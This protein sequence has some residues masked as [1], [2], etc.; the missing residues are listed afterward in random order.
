MEIP[1]PA[2][3]RTAYPVIHVDCLIQLLFCNLPCLRTTGCFNPYQFSRFQYLRP[4]LA[5]ERNI[6][7]PCRILKYP[8]GVQA[9]CVF[10]Y[11]ILAVEPAAFCPAP[12]PELLLDLLFA[13][14]L[15]QHIQKRL[16]FINLQVAQIRHHAMPIPE[17]LVAAG[18]GNVDS[19]ASPIV[20]T[21]IGKLQF[22]NRF[23]C[24]THIAAP[25]RTAKAC[26]LQEA[27]A[28]RVPD[29]AYRPP[30]LTAPLRT[31]HSS[32]LFPPQECRICQ[33]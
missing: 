7:S 20:D 5:V 32:R 1:E 18:T 27:P 24:H 15:N 23:L 17:F 2:A 30:S 19:R 10:L 25:F 14:M 21:Q 13:M 29:T 11:F 22:S 33:E 26:S 3:V 31:F 12:L 28:E 9:Q 16:P 6:A 4:V 8:G